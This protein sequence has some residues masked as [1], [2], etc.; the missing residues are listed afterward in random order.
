M[1][2]EALQAVDVELLSDI[3]CRGVAL[4]LR[5]YAISVKFY[6]QIS[7]WPLKFVRPLPVP[8]LL[9]KSDGIYRA[10]LWLRN[11]G[12]SRRLHN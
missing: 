2:Q 6:G 1:Q 11:P 8:K 3:L 10:T 5:I 4:R 7:P 9:V 12:H